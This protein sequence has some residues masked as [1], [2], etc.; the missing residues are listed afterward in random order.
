MIISKNR[1]LISSIISI[2]LILIS[3]LIFLISVIPS[4]NQLKASITPNNINR[5][6]KNSFLIPVNSYLYTNDKIVLTLPN[7]IIVN[8]SNLK[9]QLVC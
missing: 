1:L 9:C 4:T 3:I 8:P 7:Q 5:N 6:S 2:I